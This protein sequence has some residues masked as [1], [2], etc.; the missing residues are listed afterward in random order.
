[1]FVVTLFHAAWASGQSQQ[2]EQATNA[3]NYT[4]ADV[5]ANFRLW[6]SVVTSFTSQSG[7]I[8]FQTNSYTELAT[9]MNYL[10]N[11]QW[12]PS[13][14]NI[15]ITAE[16]GAA[17]NG[18]HQ[19]GFVANIN[20]A[21]AVEIVTPDGK[22]LQ[23]HIM[24]L[25]YYDASTGSNVLFAELQDSTGQLVTAN[26]VVYPNAFSDCA[27]D[28]RYTYTRA[29]FEQ[30]I[31]LQQ[32]PP[33][34]DAYGL[35]PD[36]TWLQV[37]TE[38]AD[39]PTPAIET[40]LDGTDERLDFGVMQMDRG[41]AFIMGNES[42]SVPVSKSWRT[43]QGRTF[44]VE[45][46]Q[47]DAVAAQ[48]QSLPAPSNGGSGTGGTGAQQILY[49]GFPKR[50]PLL[51]TKTNRS[52]K[53]LKL[54]H[55]QS[56]EKGLVL[57]YTLVNGSFANATFLGDT[58]YFITGT[59]NLSG[60]TTFEGGTVI[61]FT[62]NPGSLA[63]NIS[64]PIVCQTGPYHMAV[65]T[66]MDDDSVGEKVSG[67]SGN[68]SGAYAL[69]ALND[70]YTGGSVNLQYLRISYAVFGCLMGS[71]GTNWIRHCQFVNDSN[72]VWL[73]GGG[74]T[75]NLHNDLF[76]N[77]G[78]DAIFGI[79]TSINAVNVTADT[80]NTF[81]F[82]SFGSSLNLVNSLL[83]ASGA[84]NTHTG[85][86]NFT[87]SSTSVFTNA[88][89]GAHY[90]S[91]GTYRGQGTTNIDTNLLTDLR[92]LTT[93]P[94]AVPPSFTNNSTST[95]TNSTILGQYALRDTNSTLDVG[96][97]YPPI[98]YM[99]TTNYSN[100]VVELTNGAVI[101]YWG[102]AC[103]SLDNGSQLISQGGPLAGQR[104]ALAYYTLVQEQPVKLMGGDTNLSDYPGKSAPI[105]TSHSDTNRNPSLS[106]RF[107]SIFAPQNAQNILLAY[108]ASNSAISNLTIQD[109]EFFGSGAGIYL[110][111]QSGAASL[112]NNLFQYVLFTAD[113]SGSFGA[114]NNLYRGDPNGSMSVTNYGGGAITNRNNVFENLIVNIAGTNGHNAYLN[115]TL[116]ST[117]LSNDFPTNLTWVTGPLGSFYQ[118]TNS[119]LI[120]NGSTTADLLGLYH[121]TTRT[122]EAPET[123]A[124]VTI[125]YHYVALGANGLPLDANGDGIP[126]YLEDPNGNGAVDPGE[127]DWSAP[128][129]IT[130]VN[131]T[132]SSIF[133]APATITLQAS[134]SSGGVPITNVTFY[135]GTTPIGNAT[136][137]PAG[138]WTGTWS[139]NWTNVA[140]GVYSLTAVAQDAAGLSA[141]SAPVNIFVTSSCSVTF[142]ATN[143]F[144]GSYW[145]NATNAQGVLINLNYT[146]A[147]GGLAINQQITPLPYVNISCG[148]D[149][150]S[151]NATDGTMLRIDAKTNTVLGEYRT[152]PQGKPSYP[153]HVAVDRYGNTWVANWDERGLLDGTGQGSL[154][155]I[156]IVVGGTRGRIQKDTNG[157]VT[158][159]VADPN[160]QYLK[161][162]FEYSTAID[163]DGDGYIKTSHGL[164]GTNI[165]N[166]TNVPGAQSV[167]NA[168]DE[169]IISYVRTTSQLNSGLTIDANND[170]WVGGYFDSST[171]DCT[172]TSCTNN[173]VGNQ[174]HVKISGL[175]GLAVATNL[176]SSNGINGTVFGGF[177]DLVDWNGTLW[178][179]GGANQNCTLSLVRYNPNGPATNILTGSSN[180]FGLAVDPVS[181][182]VWAGLW[183]AN[184]LNV[185][186]TNQSLV[187]NYPVG[188]GLEA[189]S[190]AIDQQGD[191]W[192]SHTGPPGSPGKSISHML[193]NGHYIGEVGVTNNAQGPTGLSIDSY[194][195]VWTVGRFAPT[196]ARIDPTIG[197]SYTNTNGAVYHLGTN[198]L[199]LTLA[200]GTSF[201][202]YGDYT[203]YGLL[204]RAPAGVWSVVDDGGTSNEQWGTVTW[205]ASTTNTSQIRVEVRAA[206]RWTG[207]TTN[208]F[209]L[210]SNSASLTNFFGEF[211]E[212]RVTL[213]MPPGT[214]NSPWLHDLTVACAP[215]I[216]GVPIVTITSPTNGQVFSYPTT[217]VVLQ[218][219]AT[220]SGATVTNL[221]FYNGTNFIS[222]TNGAA[223]QYTWTNVVPGTYTIF[224]VA[225]DSLGASG[226]NS[227]TFTNNYPPFVI[228]FLSPTNNQFFFT[229]LTNIVLETIIT[230]G[231]GTVSNVALYRGVTLL[232]TATAA[233]GQT[234]LFLW[235]N[236]APGTYTFQ[237]SA[238]NSTG[239]STN[240]SV[241]NIMV[242][243]APVITLITPTN[244]THFLPGT[245]ITILTHASDSNGV[246][247][248]D[249]FSMTTNGFVVFGS[250]TNT[251]NPTSITN[252]LVLTNPP[253]G[254]YA[255]YAAAVDTNNAVGVSKIVVLQV[256]AQPTVSITSPANGAIFP[257]DI[258]ITISATAGTTNAGDSITNVEFFVNGASI[259]NDPVAPYS[260]TECCWKP[261]TY[262]LTARA[263]DTNG[264]QTDSTN[265]TITVAGEAP[266]GGGFWDEA[267]GSWTVYSPTITNTYFYYDNVNT[268][269][270][271]SDGTLYVAGFALQSY[272]E[273]TKW[274]EPFSTVLAPFNLE[275]DNGSWA[276]SY[277]NT[278]NLYLTGS[279]IDGTNAPW[280]AYNAVKWDGSQG[281][282]LGDHLDASVDQT[283]GGGAGFVI[284]NIAGDF[285]AGGV[286]PST[287]DGTSNVKYIA[288]L[289]GTNWVQVGNGIN[290]G[291]VFAIAALGNRIYIGGSFTNAGGDS[292][293]NY[294]AELVGT[295]WTHLG[296]GVSGATQAGGVVTSLAACGSN[297][298]VGGYFDTAGGNTNANGVA[299][300][301]GMTWRTMNGGIGVA[302]DFAT[303]RYPNESTEGPYP[304]LPLV[305]TI[306]ARGNRVFVGGDFTYIL[307]GTNSMPANSIAT[308]LWNEN[309]QTWQWSDLD[310]GVGAPPDSFDIVQSSL[311]AEGS[312]AGAYDLYVGGNFD[313]VGASQMP[314]FQIARWRVGTLN[315]NSNA[316]PTVLITSPAN[317]SVYTNSTNITVLATVKWLTSAGTNLPAALYANGALIS[318]TNEYADNGTNTS[319]F[320]FHWTN[321]AHGVYTLQATATQNQVGT[322]PAV[323]VSIKGTNNPVV[324]HDDTYTVLIN[325]ATN[326]YVLSNDTSSNG[327][328]H[329]AAA[330]PLGE[331][332]GT[333]SAW[334]N[335]RFLTY[336]PAPYSYGQDNFTYFAEDAQ[337]NS[338]QAHVTV[339]VLAPPLISFLNSYD[340]DTFPANTIIPI[341]VR[342]LGYDA[343]VT[344]VTVL[345]NGASVFATSGT[346]L[347]NFTFN[348]SNSVANFYT[349]VAVAVDADGITNLSTPMTIAL[350]NTNTAA[351]SLTASITNLPIKVGLV[352][353]Y[354][355]VQQ[356]LFELKGQA[357]MSGSTNTL[358]YQLMLFRPQDNSDQGL[359]DTTVPYLNVTPVP[360]G[361]AL[362]AAGFRLGG[363]SGGDLGQLNFT[364]IPNGIYDL[365]LTVEGNGAETFAVARFQLY[366]QMKIGQLSF[367]QQDLALPANG[368]PLTVTRTYN[369]MNPESADFGY[370]WTY[371]LNTM[372]VQLDEQRTT[373]YRGD[374]HLSLDDSLDQSG[375]GGPESV[376]IRTGGGRN[377]TITLPNGRQTTFQFSPQLGGLGYQAVWTAPSDVHASLETIGLP[378]IQVLTGLYWN[379]GGEGSSWDNYDVPGWKLTTQDGT[380][381]FIKRLAEGAVTYTPDPVGNSGSNVLVQPYGPPQL[382]EILERT[383]D[384]IMINDNGMT[385]YD[386]N[387]VGTRSVYFDRD[388][389]NRITALYDAIAGPTGFPVVKYI[390]NQDTGNL[391][392]VLKL[393]DRTAGTY[394]TNLY[395]Y[396]NPNFPHYITAIVDADGVPVAE[397][398]YDANGLLT[399]STDA[400]GNVTTFIH[401]T[402]N[403]V[404]VVVDR[405][406]NTNSYAYDTNGNVTA[407][408]NALHQVTTMAYDALNDKTSE[409]IGGLQTNSYAYDGNSYMLQSIIGGLMTNTFTYNTNNGEVLTSTDGNGNV[410]TNNYDPN[411]GNLLSTTT[412]LSTNTFTY[413]N[414][415]MTSSVDALGNVTTNYYDG[416]GNLTATAALDI[417][418]TILSTNS[419]AY[420]ANGNQTSSTVWRHVPGNT[421]WISATTTYVYDGQNRVVQTI[422]ALSNTNTTVYDANGRQQT[423]IDARNHQ[424]QYYY[425]DRGNLTNTLYADGSSEQSAYDADA[426]RTNS[427]DRAG[428][429]TTYI[430]DSL[431][432]VSQTIYADATTNTTVYNAAGR[433]AYSVDARGTTNAFGYDAAG[434]RTSVTNAWGTSIAM[435]NAFGYDASGNQTNVADNLGRTTAYTFDA[436]NRMTKT[437]FPDHSTQLTAYDALGRK[438]ASTDPATNTTHFG[439]DG[440]GR[441]TSV[442]NA[443]NQVTRYAYD[444]AGNQL[445]QVDA[446]LRTNGYAYDGL[447]RRI[448]HI[449]PGAQSE[450]FGY[451]L[452][453]NLLYQTN[454]T[455]IV[456]TNQ[457]DVMNRLTNR[458]STNGFSVAYGYNV[459]GQRANMTDASG[460]YSYGYDNRDRLKLKTVSWAGGP[461]ISLNYGYDL[462]G[463]L[464]N[465][466]SSSANGVTN[467]YQYD[468]L[469]RLT[470]VL[471][472]G[473]AAA[474]YGFDGV[475]NLQSLHY[476]NGVT[477]LYQYDSLNRLTNLVW[478]TN[479]NTIASFYYQLGFTGNRT[480][481][482]EIVGTVNRTN[483]W[484]YDALYRLTNEVIVAPTNAT[485]GY[486]YDVVGNRLNR[487]VTGSGVS[488]TN[489]TFGF[490]TNDW[491]TNTDTY[492]SDGNTK[493]SAGRTYGYDALDRIVTV[494]NG[495]TTI[496]IGYDGDGNRVSKTISGVTEFYLV[497][498]R[499]PSGYAQVLEE[500]VVGSGSTNL[501]RVYAYGLDLINQ[502]T[503]GASTTYYGYDGHGSTRFLTST[504]GA[505]TDTYV[506]DA[507]GTLTG[508]T[509]STANNYLYSDEQY[510]SDLG[511]YYLRARYLNPNTGRFWTLDSYEGENEDPPSLHKYLYCH[512][513][514]Q[515]GIDANGHDFIETLGTFYV[516]AQLSAATFITTYGAYAGAITLITAVSASEAVQLFATGMTE[517]GESAGPM[518]YAMAAITILPGGQVIKKP[519]STVEKDM[520]RADA[521][522]LWDVLSKIP[523]A[524]GDRIHHRIPLEWAHIFPKVDPNSLSNLEKVADADH[525]DINTLWREFKAALNGRKPTRKE[526]LDQAKAIDIK[527]GKAIPSLEQT[528]K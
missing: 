456:V 411:S 403:Q 500:W 121:Y 241:T 42:N 334:G 151:N 267:F 153:G 19:V 62:N 3:V 527:Y 170:V 139:L 477:N 388:S 384:R 4:I 352:T 179:S 228:S 409:V 128:P 294:I 458:S 262:T 464:T 286:F 23:T 30:D 396:D 162:P 480:N 335:G 431:N 389:Q 235:T 88:G 385:H 85:S 43:I 443:L 429:V 119:P 12:M 74:G 440:T 373:Y 436:L 111:S 313:Y 143:I 494:T 245:N 44:L 469:S 31:V 344:S 506:Y 40:S 193:T 311:I 360:P 189:A 16:G 509:G 91:G 432:R 113:V 97:H 204:S 6:Q 94:P 236:V 366:T 427:T 279:T 524:I 303:R 302:D 200:N 361:G 68:P 84:G 486:G 132:N 453:G 460:S 117:V 320:S 32:Q 355:V 468:A 227:V 24:G 331:T 387:G 95:V 281:T 87:N 122:N 211:L 140:S 66:G 28:V 408:T 488:L 257:P 149:N 492:D 437:T 168:E 517:D 195:R 38:F 7:Q 420:D 410:T 89:A 348:W 156:G 317:Y 444:E 208:T 1:V 337:G 138:G 248:V 244:S 466:W 11:G 358:A 220:D 319:Y 47:Y 55:K 504:N 52:N 215:A 216:A 27:A 324:A 414:G 45:Q 433:V 282:A 133:S 78:G 264:L 382:T 214:T 115:C 457:Y 101:G 268:M 329:I 300:W 197:A 13:K 470:N 359:D 212:I 249:F 199:N 36:T 160:G 422:D 350:T 338:D 386:T 507:Y 112:V 412:S 284:K 135:W 376:S 371:V 125:G 312:N 391:I 493:S 39:P 497:D 166:W 64:G 104:N 238:T 48:I 213:L 519:L 342:V 61:K 467:A 273:Q 202:S 219:S 309:E 308:A 305:Y 265:V 405:M 446:L 99:T 239:Q 423:T 479:G 421:N 445:T 173:A 196:I 370:G 148:D 188:S 221:A 144:G 452:V 367:S 439:Y 146:N 17:T 502:R 327:P 259:G 186:G 56:P 490:N 332:K 75:V 181:G 341:S 229:S 277:A 20:S 482:V 276:G 63:L 306:A 194:G 21:N 512:G 290:N 413:S 503:I 280:L 292:N 163:R 318:T 106:L 177:E 491:L 142:S 260:I 424:T 430:H 513:N 487:T 278:T 434:R 72:P 291:A 165:L 98:D 397:N 272:N 365:Q 210:V 29:G 206:N 372:N 473:S 274:T 398:Q 185:Y 339:N 336:K 182:L 69:D 298:F 150:A 192:V 275:G 471:A 501:S 158:N 22:D 296:S 364:G 190:V 41:K 51:P 400:D 368:I 484:Q 172:N 73:G 333:V 255:I 124:V 218:A 178:S 34:P 476:G 134:A 483:R 461:A 374:P 50:L 10:S 428:H 155:R 136:S 354:T 269:A 343:P 377:V 288:R 247:R 508:S 80:V 380:Q 347:G 90:L 223:Y 100:C 295:N 5:G 105:V 15:Q 330:S 299:I 157:V 58:T 198:D 495:S 49:Q 528:S 258:D 60:T 285:Y 234:N 442:T 325:T 226:T 131:P 2:I 33:L 450:T 378:G 92:L 187:T 35:N 70:T 109:C 114:F 475:G 53:R 176:F 357:Q 209:Q 137:G 79:N 515:N 116:R 175:T 59:V 270:F 379:D 8:L 25:S 256:G 392:Q 383:G 233:L 77:I 416:M 463:N 164:D 455:G 316:A 183:G 448:Q 67:S 152:A 141:T 522:Q 441:L 283:Y 304:F 224:A 161:P 9:G 252:S 516:M 107:T 243:D 474:G 171:T 246:H 250:V 314:S 86:N 498:D 289:Q 417:N 393:Q 526:I 129:L 263:T 201:E 315:T 435:T 362:N 205:N 207:L 167:T 525:K 514:P 375:D 254:T 110:Y 449:M 346:N 26:Q 415:L 462:N 351:T 127:T 451:D 394:V 184:T 297:L 518:D 96:Y 438:V 459:T 419:F 123:N 328:L 57:D 174:S 253:P 203:G 222:Q 472:G 481:L 14:E 369:S 130:L 120:T 231:S 83:V 447:G 510:D 356:G 237:A 251:A 93:Y 511:F 71:S 321:I 404:D 395:R 381:Y 230:G 102:S 169:C 46:V 454:F 191:V 240:A 407:I 478:K 108:S 65:L 118:P 293:A 353:N 418:N 261:G 326:L 322:S 425:D 401:N 399:N 103:I 349:F 345:T 180:Y 287:A 82:N 81:Y 496:A 520:Y 406:G 499:N 426:R 242:N 485:L 323:Y 271:T 54:A 301:N 76:D 126:D 225:T 363:D 154:T 232:G 147:S 310:V 307:N 18:Q 489:Q 402:S 266:D 340:G 159:F 523:R 390:Y 217:N 145:T 521:R 37:W 505:T 465:L